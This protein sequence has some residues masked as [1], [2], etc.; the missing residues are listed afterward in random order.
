MLFG[1][2]VSKETGAPDGRARPERSPG[3]APQARV[4]EVGRKRDDESEHERTDEILQDD[5][6]RGARGR[7]RH[8]EPAERERRR[9]EDADQEAAVRPPWLREVD[10]DRPRSAV[11][12]ECPISVI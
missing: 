9:E 12:N 7:G 1:A 8:C 5:T 10:R 11:R 6:H 3:H 2:S 4:D